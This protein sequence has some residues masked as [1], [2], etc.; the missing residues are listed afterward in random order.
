M[1]KREEPCAKTEL[2]AL[3]QQIHTTPADGS[4]CLNLVEA[5]QTYAPWSGLKMHS[6][7]LGEK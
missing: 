1:H 6:S 3:S 7:T 4:L 2:K 5:G